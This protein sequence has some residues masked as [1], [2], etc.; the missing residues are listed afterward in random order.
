MS[1]LVASLQH[2]S[3]P[4]NVRPSP[5]PSP[6]KAERT[7]TGISATA[8]APNVEQRQL[9]EVVVVKLCAQRAVC[10]DA[11]QWLRI[12]TLVASTVAG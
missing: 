4:C 9:E 7:R 1:Y 5:F 3:T 6:S 2:S 12:R 10:S 11:S 8:V